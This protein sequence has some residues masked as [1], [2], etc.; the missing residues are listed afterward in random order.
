MQI[1]VGPNFI[2]PENVST[3]IFTINNSSFTHS[4]VCLT[5]NGV[6]SLIMHP[7]PFSV[8]RETNHVLA[9]WYRPCIRSV[10]SQTK[11]AG[12]AETENVE[13]IV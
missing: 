4:M 9:V 2:L 8:H 1:S 10:T 3:D 6:K 12:T 11:T 5:I 7:L 13:L